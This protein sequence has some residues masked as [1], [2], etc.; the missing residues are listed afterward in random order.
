L[1]GEYFG[2]RTAINAS[3]SS[4]A[5]TINYDNFSVIPEPSTALALLSGIGILGLRRRRH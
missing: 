3:G 2:Y 1:T 4:A 5:E